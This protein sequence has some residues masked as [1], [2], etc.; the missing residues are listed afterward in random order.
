MSPLRRRTVAA[1]RRQ[2]AAGLRCINGKAHATGRWRKFRRAH[3]TI[4]V[5]AE[6]QR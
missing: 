5:A 2:A 6:V 3:A 1:I 4:M